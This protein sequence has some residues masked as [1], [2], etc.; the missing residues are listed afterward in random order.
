MLKPLRLVCATR[1]DRDT[2]FTSAALGR[3]LGVYLSPFIQLKLYD[4]NTR[5][6]PSIYNDAIAQAVTDPAVLVFIHDDVYLVDF[7]WPDHLRH[8][9]TVFD[10]V[11]V[12]G[13]RRRVPRQP[14]WCFVDESLRPDQGEYLS[15]IVGHGPAFPPQVITYFGPPRQQ[16][17]LLDGVLLAADSQTLVTKGLRFDERFDFHFYDLDF[18][19][20]AEQL[21]LKMGTWPLSIIHQSGGNFRSESWWSSYAKYLDKWRE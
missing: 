15:G 11:G 3:S 19:R 1:S 9:L 5:G 12:A 7:Y 21:E 16:V 14:G 4:S 13:N 8:A 17:K 10:I 18:C 6:L 2:F 20:Q